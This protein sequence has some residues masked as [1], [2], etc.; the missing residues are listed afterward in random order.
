MK[1]RIVV[2]A[3]V[4]VMIG[5]GVVVGQS[6]ASN[7]SEAS[8]AK[9]LSA[10]E[11]RADFKLLRDT[12]FRLHPGVYRYLPKQA[13]DRIWDSCYG[14]I[15]DSMTAPE[16]FTLTS[17]AIAS[18][19]DGH[20]NCRLPRGVVSQYLS[21]VKVFPALV[22]FLHQHAY[23][24]CCKQND[25]LDG[26]EILEL[27]GRPMGQVIDRIFQYISSDAGIE[28]RKN[29]E[30]PDNF[31]LLYNLVV[32][33][34]ENYPVVYRAK[35]GRVGRVNLKAGYLSDFVCRPPAVFSRPSRYLTL[36]YRPGN[37]G[38]LTVR[39]FLTP[40]LGQTG[41]NFQGFLDSAFTDLRVKGVRKLIIDIRRNQGGDDINGSL[42]YA[43]LSSK[44][45]RYYDSLKTVKGRWSVDRHPNLRVQEPRPNHF[46]GEVFI[47]AD[48]RS[49]SASSEFSSIVKSNNRGKF[50]GEE[51]GGGYYG[52]TSGGDEEVVLPVSRINCR[53]S[54]VNY[55]LAVKKLK[56][57]ELGILPDYPVYPT[58][59]DFI[60]GT[61]SQLEFAVK[62][63][64]GN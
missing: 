11:L 20:S 15:R 56:G 8:Y 2:L 58:I 35:D 26:A 1:K 54:L 38:V 6:A 30:L 44:P 5:R 9:K 21:A 51:N 46:D 37:I 63:A 24:Y 29:W 49:F 16:F 27:C 60:N 40:F 62:V 64:A 14:S 28:S 25:S 34:Q 13:M 12:L 3:C 32:G 36:D 42:L 23:V 55:Y 61:D 47:L 19:K 48:G 33:V 43:Y 57:G 22:L 59:G 7:V 45:F 53:I 39:T 10:G 17:F 18:L 31:N 41:E 4:L 50:V 52:N